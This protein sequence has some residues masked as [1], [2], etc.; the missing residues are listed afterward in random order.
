MMRYAD[1][2]GGMR[3]SDERFHRRGPAG[4]R[5]PVGN[6][7]QHP[8]LGTTLPLSLRL[9]PA[10]L[11]GAR[12]TTR[13][14]TAFTI[15]IRPRCA[16]PVYNKQ[17]HNYYP[18]RPPVSLGSPLHSRHVL[19]SAAGR[20]VARFDSPHLAIRRSSRACIAQLKKAEGLPSDSG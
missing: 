14:Q 11:S 3:C 15:D 18:A 2:S 13:A 9:L 6:Q 4:L 7:L 8:G 5:P 1:T 20:T 17:W 10:E 19:M 16:L 12:I